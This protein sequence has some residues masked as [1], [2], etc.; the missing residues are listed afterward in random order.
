MTRRM[1]RS[2]CLPEITSVRETPAEDRVRLRPLARSLVRTYAGLLGI[3]D[4]EGMLAL[5]G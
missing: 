3:E 2:G 5:V 1:R 4:P